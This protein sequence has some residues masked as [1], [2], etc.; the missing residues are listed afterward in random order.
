M[1]CKEKL[2]FSQLMFDFE[3]V[4][5]LIYVYANQTFPQCIHFLSFL[6]SL[7]DKISQSISN[8]YIQL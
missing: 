8:R 7:V 5:E 4:F 3:L 6:K 1:S 2:C